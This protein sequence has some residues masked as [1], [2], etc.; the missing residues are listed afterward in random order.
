MIASI[1]PMDMKSK[2]SDEIARETQAFLA[3]GKAV[4][5][6]P[7]GIGHHTTDT[8]RDFQSK[9]AKINAATKAAKEAGL[10]YD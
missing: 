9:V 5:E 8:Y 2:M 6:I 3:Q 10:L 4:N 1:V 7:F